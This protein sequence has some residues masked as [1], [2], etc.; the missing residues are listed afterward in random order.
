M[1]GLVTIGF[2]TGGIKPC[3][4]AFGGDQFEKGHVSSEF[5]SL[6][7]YFCILSIVDFMQNNVT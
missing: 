3:V 7:L 4:S 5:S 6:I 2:G 1:V